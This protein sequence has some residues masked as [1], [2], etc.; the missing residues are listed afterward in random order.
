MPLSPNRE[1]EL[2]RDIKVLKKIL[3]EIIE[4]SIIFQQKVKEQMPSGRDAKRAL[5]PDS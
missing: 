5:L 4:R 3:Y 2:K 1:V